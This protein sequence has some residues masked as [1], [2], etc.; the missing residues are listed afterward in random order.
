MHETTANIP[1]HGPSCAAP[2]IT[3]LQQYLRGMHTAGCTLQG[4]SQHSAGVL[5]GSQ[6]C[7]SWQPVTRLYT[8]W[9]V[10]ELV[11]A[12]RKLAR[13]SRGALL[14]HAFQRC[15]GHK[16]IPNPPSQAHVPLQ[17]RFQ[18]ACI[19]CF[20]A[21]QPTV[22]SSFVKGANKHKS[23]VPLRFL[24]CWADSTPPG[25]TSFICLPVLCAA[26]VGLI[27]R[28]VGQDKPSAPSLLSQKTSLIRLAKLK[29]S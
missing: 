11:R 17:F 15:N 18:T 9:T 20:K 24:C 12:L 14:Q 25:V 2:G 29:A 23:H 13:A 1:L 19:C 5:R 28:R 3:R 8:A 21:S 4:S 26:G 7:R 10:K 6:G 27:L 22:H 16:T